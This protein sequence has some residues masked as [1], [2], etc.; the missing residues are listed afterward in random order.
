MR[1]RYIVSYTILEDLNN[2][3]NV[4]TNRFLGLN[5]GVEINLF[6]IVWLICVREKVAFDC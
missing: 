1:Y 3:V 5:V 2:Y 4:H 6:V